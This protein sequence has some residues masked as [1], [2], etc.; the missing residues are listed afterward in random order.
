[1]KEALLRLFIQGDA[2]DIQPQ[3]MFRQ[4]TLKFYSKFKFAML[5]SLVWTQVHQ[6]QSSTSP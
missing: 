3:S 2:K 1:M 6:C 4:F 5:I